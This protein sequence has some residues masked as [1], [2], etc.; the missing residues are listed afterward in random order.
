MSRTSAL[1]EVIPEQRYKGY[2]FERAIIVCQR[3]GAG[4]SPSLLI[5]FDDG[6]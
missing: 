3:S 6:I 2:N 4:L 5:A 1:G